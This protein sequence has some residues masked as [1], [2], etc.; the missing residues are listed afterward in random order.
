MFKSVGLGMLQGVGL[1]TLGNGNPACSLVFSYHAYGLSM[2][3]MLTCTIWSSTDWAFACCCTCLLR[4]V[5]GLSVLQLANILTV[6]QLLA[7]IKL[8]YSV[9]G[10]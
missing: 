6:Q 3:T 4:P 2:T 8:A 10:R 5:C 7:A 9:W 1:G